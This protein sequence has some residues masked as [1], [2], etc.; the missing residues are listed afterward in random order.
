MEHPLGKAEETEEQKLVTTE[1]HGCQGA[2]E[3]KEEVKEINAISENLTRAFAGMSQESNIPKESRGCLD[4]IPETVKVPAD[5]S[6]TEK[7]EDE[8]KHK[9]SQPTPR[10]PEKESAERKEHP[11]EAAK[12]EEAKVQPD[13]FWTR[14]WGEK[15]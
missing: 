10:Q 4:V 15:S 11:G 5:V 9:Q 6:V 12:K 1:D 14:L 3:D 13:N 2:E 7:L 8:S